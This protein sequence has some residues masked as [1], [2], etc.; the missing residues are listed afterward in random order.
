MGT[1]RRT[2]VSPWAGRLKNQSGTDDGG[3]PFRQCPPQGSQPPPPRLPRFP[4]CAGP[5][6][7]ASEEETPR[8]WCANAEGSLALRTLPGTDS[9]TSLSQPGTHGLRG[10]PV[11]WTGWRSP[12]L[13]P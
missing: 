1:D 2:R 12:Q 11:C 10:S 9:R 6:L 5:G 4:A 13:L 3:W 7:M 8:R